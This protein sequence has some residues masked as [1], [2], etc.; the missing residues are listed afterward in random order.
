MNKITFVLCAAI[1]VSQTNVGFAQ[2]QDTDGDGKLNAPDPNAG[3]YGA[4]RRVRTKAPDEGY[5]AVKGNFNIPQESDLN[6]PNFIGDFFDLSSGNR[7]RS[8]PSFYFGCERDEPGDE[9]VQAGLQVDAGFQYESQAI[10]VGGN[11]DNDPS[12]IPPGWG[13]FVRTTGKYTDS[14]GVTI[15]AGTNASVTYWRC[16][17]DTLNSDVTSVDLLWTYYKFASPSPPFYGGYLEV[18]ALNA[19]GPIPDKDQPKDQQFFDRKI[20]ARTNPSDFFSSIYTIT[21]SIANTRVKRV[22]AMTQGTTPGSPLEFPVPNGG[23]YQE[24]GSYFLNSRFSN[25]MVSK[26]KPTST[27]AS[28]APTSWLTW[29]VAQTDV[30]DRSAGATGYYPGGLNSSVIGYQLRP[31]FLPASSVKTVIGNAAGA[32]KIFQFPSIPEANWDEAL[33]SRYANETVS[34]N[35]RGFTP[36]SGFPISL[37]NSGK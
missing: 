10:K 17:P 21:D 6:V 33:S 35:L 30:S 4:N 12:Y 29:D 16:G 26:Q 25:G 37:G 14:D 2:D 1:A 3:Q 9:E 28:W 24:D 7:Y 8:K 15:A 11:A 13:I 5:T 27:G 31:P 32:E 34:I 19:S 20:R 36:A 18:N 22:V 23:I